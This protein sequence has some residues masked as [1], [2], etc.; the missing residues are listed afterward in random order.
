M[1]QLYLKGKNVKSLV[2]IPKA[3]MKLVPGIA[4]TNLAVVDLDTS[5]IV[6]H[7]RRT[8]HIQRSHDWNMFLL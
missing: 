3:T 1:L 6:V 8:I 5:I 7:R 2:E 4:V